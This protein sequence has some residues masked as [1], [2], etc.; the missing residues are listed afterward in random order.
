MGAS[1][2]GCL[3]QKGASIGLLM[4]GMSTLSMKMSLKTK[5]L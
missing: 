5:L 2:R 4:L 3:G 1:F